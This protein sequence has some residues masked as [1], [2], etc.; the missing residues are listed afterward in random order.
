MLVQG[1]NVS[2]DEMCEIPSLYE[3]FLNSEWSLGDPLSE[4]P[5]EEIMT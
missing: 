1:V 2:F 3:W 4:L 5:M